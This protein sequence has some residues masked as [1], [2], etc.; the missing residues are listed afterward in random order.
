MDKW[1]VVKRRVVSEKAFM[2]QDEGKYA[3]VVD[4]RANKPEIK[5][6][7][8]S[9]FGVNVERVS[10]LNTKGKVKVFKGIKGKRPSLKKAIVTLKEGESL[11]EL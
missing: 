6:A 7:I 8:E 9:I 11:K 5:K 10:I 4:K 1:N 2:G 3:F